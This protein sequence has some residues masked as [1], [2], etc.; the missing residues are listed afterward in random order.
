[1]LRTL[2]AAAALGL[3]LATNPAAADVTVHVLHVDPNS[4]ALWEGIADDYNK[5]HSGVKVVVE[6]LEN[7]A[8]K[9]KLPISC[10]RTTG[11]TSSIAGPAA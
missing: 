4:R 8:F 2:A 9:A 3:A 6:Y 5:T 10:N 7:E 11:R 1:M